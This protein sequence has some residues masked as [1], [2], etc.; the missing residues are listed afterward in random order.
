M[1][2]C[3]LMVIAFLVCAAPPVALTQDYSTSIVGTDFDLI[4]DS[5]PSCF[6]SL[7]FDRLDKRAEMPDKTRDG[8]FRPAYVFL[9]KYSDATQLRVFVDARFGDKDTAFN[10]AMR[11]AER[12]GKLPTALRGGIRRLVIHKSD[13]ETTAFSD[14]GLIVVYSANA[15]KR[16][17]DNDLEETLFHESVHASWDGKY[18]KSERWKRAQFADGAFATVYAKRKPELEDLAESALFAFAVI[19]HPERLPRED[20]TKIKKAIPNRILF[21]ESLLPATKPLIF[22]ADL[23]AFCDVNLSRTGTAKDIIAN[24]LRRHYQL[25]ESQIADCL[26]NLGEEMIVATARKLNLDEKEFRKQVEKLKHVNCE[27]T[28]R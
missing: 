14:L 25:N 21:I 9:S 6:E 24:T 8:L 11:Y 2:P 15:T 26:E 23:V 28:N 1:I 4:T 3:R 27:H 7:T 12:L 20:L 13:Q 5:D 19:H 10:E 16:I 17:A 18:A 22:K